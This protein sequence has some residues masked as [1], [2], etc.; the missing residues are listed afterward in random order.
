[1][2]ERQDIQ[3]ECLGRS[4]NQLRNRQIQRLLDLPF[5]HPQVATQVDRQ[6]IDD[7]Q[8]IDGTVRPC[9]DHAGVVRVVQTGIDQESIF[10]SSKLAGQEPV[11]SGSLRHVT[12]QRQRNRFVGR[13]VA[14]Q[15]QTSDCRPGLFSGAHDA[16]EGVLP[17]VPADGHGDP[18]AQPVEFRVARLVVESDDLNLANHRFLG[19]RSFDPVAFLVLQHLRRRG[20]T[21]LFAAERGAENQ[22]GDH[23][24]REGHGEVRAGPPVGARRAV[25][26]GEPRDGREKKQEQRDHETRDGG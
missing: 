24:V 9:C 20:G 25:P 19:N 6:L 16:N 18:E 26:P 1:M 11:D 8:G 17:E 14:F 2:N 3:A 15:I 4:R 12:E 21:Q 7:L 5:G 10:I 13:G 22:G 23:Q